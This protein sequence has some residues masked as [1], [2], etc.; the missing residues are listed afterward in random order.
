MFVLQKPLICIQ[1]KTS[2]HYTGSVLGVYPSCLSKA[3]VQKKTVVTKR[4]A[5]QTLRI[6]GK[7][8]RCRRDRTLDIGAKL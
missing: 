1:F 7:V 2:N 6:Q 5:K 8:F 3:V 4:D